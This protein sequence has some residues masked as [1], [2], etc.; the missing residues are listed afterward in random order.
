[1]LKSRQTMLSCRCLAWRR[2]LRSS[3]SGGMGYARLT[4]LCERTDFSCAALLLAPQSPC[5]VFTPLDCW[6]RGFW[7]GCDRLW[8][9]VCSVQRLAGPKRVNFTRADI[10]LQRHP[11]F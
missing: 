8:L 6:A 5:P 10:N 3:L 2:Q 4:K 9:G 7:L 11:A 1:M